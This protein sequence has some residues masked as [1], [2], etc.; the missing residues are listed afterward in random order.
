MDTYKFL[1][2]EIRLMEAKARDLLG[3]F[4]TSKYIYNDCFSDGCYCFNSDI[5]Q[6]GPSRLR[7]KAQLDPVLEYLRIRKCI[8]EDVVITNSTQRG[9]KVFVINPQCLA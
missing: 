4:A 7:T 2:D 9:R 1:F 5:L 8:R 6:F 3:W